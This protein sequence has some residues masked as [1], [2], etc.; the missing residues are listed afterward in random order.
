[1]TKPV[2]LNIE[3]S[4]P[5]KRNPTVMT[6]PN[7][8]QV[9]QARSF[10][11]TATWLWNPPSGLN[12]PGIQNPVFNYDRKTEYHIT[13][14]STTGCITVDTLLVDLLS[15]APNV[16]V[17]KA[18][19]P[20]GDGH[21]DLLF[22][23]TVNI[24]QLKSFIIYNRWGQKVFETSQT[25]QGWDGKLNGVA[26]PMDVYIWILQAIGI[27]GEKFRATGQVVLLR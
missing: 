8:P 24:T 11:N 20:N 5:G 25:G 9:L 18:W 4:P 16:F 13:I 19:S 7:Q 15:T 10:V 14:T 27:N 6:L 2:Q 3:T 17:P 21:N 22:P 12:N 1:M 23:N 26:Q